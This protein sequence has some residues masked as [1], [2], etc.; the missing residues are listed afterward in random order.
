M[1]DFLKRSPRPD[2]ST[3]T[4]PV[5]HTGV[6]TSPQLHSCPALLFTNFFYNYL[7]L[8]HKRVELYE[9]LLVPVEVIIGNNKIVSG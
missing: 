1:E 6:L 3:L 5:R 7:T 4:Y 8:F 9:L 2:V